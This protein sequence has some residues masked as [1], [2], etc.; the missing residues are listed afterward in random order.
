MCAHE[1]CYP[2]EGLTKVCSTTCLALIY[3]PLKLGIAL[4]HHCCDNA[5]I[6]HSCEVLELI[7]LK[8]S[9]A[10]HLGT[11]LECVVGR[12]CHRTTLVEAQDEGT[13]IFIVFLVFAAI[14]LLLNQILILGEG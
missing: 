7:I 1:I 10:D 8:D 4:W 11:L 12:A 3:T 5:V 14:V 2:F 13:A 6:I 9:L